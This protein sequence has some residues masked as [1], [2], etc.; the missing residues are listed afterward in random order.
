MLD[1]DED[2]LVP[3]S[4]LQE[5][6]RAAEGDFEA[7]CR[8]VK[9][10]DIGLICYTSG[11]TGR[12]KGVLLSHDN[13]VRTAEIYCK[14]EDVREGDDYLAYLPM[15]W[16]GDSLYGLCAA[17]MVGSAINCPESPETLRRDLRELSPMGIIAAPRMWEM[18]LSDILVRANDSSRAE[19][20]RVRLFPQGRRTGGN[21]PGGGQADPV[22]APPALPARRIPGLRAGPRPAGLPPHALGAD[23]RGA[24]RAPT[25]S[26]SSGPSAST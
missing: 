15:A 18:M 21:L 8:E 1:Y 20:L 14:A 17:L 19:A 7:L 26:A 9:P 25:P 2:I 13:L 24:A 11:T 23:R 4:D 6:G 22:G 10:G 5:E 3:F 12:P 16:V